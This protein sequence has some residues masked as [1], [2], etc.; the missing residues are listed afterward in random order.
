[1]SFNF[2]RLIA[3]IFL[4]STVYSMTQPIHEFWNFLGV[5]GWWIMQIFIVVTMML[6]TV[7]E[8]KK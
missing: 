8:E 4:I 6:I 2:H 5:Q 7:F 1:M 3:S